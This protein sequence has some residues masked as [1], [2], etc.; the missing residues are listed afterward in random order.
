MVILPSILKRR[1]AGTAQAEAKLFA[2]PKHSNP[3]RA[4]AWSGGEIHQG[5]QARAIRNLIVTH[6]TSAGTDNVR[7][8]S[9]WHI[10]PRSLLPTSAVPE[11]GAAVGPVG[12]IISTVATIGADDSGKIVEDI[13]CIVT[14]GDTL[15][16]GA[17]IGVAEGVTAGELDVES[18]TA[19][20]AGVPSFGWIEGACSVPEKI[21]FGD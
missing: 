5:V 19:V 10:L 12:T 13:G 15:E 14:I 3:P 11:D 7:I 4:A 6:F 21:G 17:E 9:A 8:N 20:G 2:H 16:K 1:S 18:A